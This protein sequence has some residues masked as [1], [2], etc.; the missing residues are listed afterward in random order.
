MLELYFFWDGGSIFLTFRLGCIVR[1]S[2]IAL[3]EH[4][5]VTLYTFLG[6][7]YNNRD[8]DGKI[9]NWIGI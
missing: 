4:L 6:L 5:Q 3:L 7:H 9:P 8:F 1:A 2:P